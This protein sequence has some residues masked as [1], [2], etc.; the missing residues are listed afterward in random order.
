MDILRKWIASVEKSYHQVLHDLVAPLPEESNKPIQ[1]NWTDERFNH[2]IDLK[3]EAL[4]KGREIWA[5]Y[6]WVTIYQF[7]ESEH[8]LQNLLYSKSIR[9]YVLFSFSVCIIA[10]CIIPYS[11]YRV[12]VYLLILIWITF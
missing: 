3:E 5:D 10:Y 7:F 4:N 11:I 2:V 1:T 8:N 6:V 9:Y 12:P